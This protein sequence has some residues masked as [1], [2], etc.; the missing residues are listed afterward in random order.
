[1]LRWYPGLVSH[2]RWCL[3]RDIDIAETKLFNQNFWLFV[4]EFKEKWKVC[5]AFLFA[6]LTIGLEK[7][8]KN[9]A[10]YSGDFKTPPLYDNVVSLH[11]DVEKRNFKLLQ[12]Y[13]LLSLLG[14]IQSNTNLANYRIVRI[15]CA[16]KVLYNR[17]PQLW[18]F[19]KRELN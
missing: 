9:L 6:T 18:P 5:P 13:F 14:A 11:A 16:L 1:M 4:L 15:K 19:E 2:C 7:Q 8:V 12:W 10:L 17:G 3:H